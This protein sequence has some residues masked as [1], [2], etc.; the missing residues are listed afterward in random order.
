MGS[1]LSG[2]D[3]HDAL[4]VGRRL[5][6]LRERQG[7]SLS[8][9]ATAMADEGYRWTKVTLSRVELGKRPLRLTEAKA[10]LECM[11]LPWRPYVL[12]LLSD[13][14]F[15]TTSHFGDVDEDE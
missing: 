13:D 7:L 3:E 4:W 6:Q 1:N 2:L 11:R 9:V 14:P 8:E 12:L 5:R 15:E 10:V